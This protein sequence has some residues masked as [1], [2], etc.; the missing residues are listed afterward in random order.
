MNKIPMRKHNRKTLFEN[1]TKNFAH[2]HK[3]GY[4]AYALNKN[5]LKK[6][7]FQK[8]GH[9]NFLLGYDSTNIFLIWVPSQKKVIR[10]RDVICDESSYYNSTELDLIKIFKEL[11][12]ED[13]YEV[14][15]LV[16]I[17]RITELDSDTDDEE[18]GMKNKKKTKVKDIGPEL[19]TP[20]LSFPELT[21]EAADDDDD[22]AASSLLFSRFKTFKNIVGD[23]SK[24]NILPEGVKKFRKKRQIHAFVLKHVASRFTKAFHIAFVC[25]IS[26]K[27]VGNLLKKT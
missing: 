25:F 14:P 21:S 27:Y 24:S 16:N 22:N 13:I 5:I 15:S 3:F 19:I 11:M 8:L 10:T 26:F 6:N 9:L 23:F 7:K 1:I 12:V 4:K 17:S 20:Y 2:L 18:I